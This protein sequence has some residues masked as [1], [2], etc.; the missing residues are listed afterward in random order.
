MRSFRMTLLPAALLVL[1]PIDLLA[2][3]EIDASRMRMAESATDKGNNFLKKQNYERAEREFTRAIEHES[4]YPQAHLGLAAVQVATGRYQQALAAV[5]ASKEHFQWWARLNQTSGLQDRQ[6]F[7]SREREMRDFARITRQNT[8][9]TTA[10]S[11]NAGGSVA[12]DAVARE[13]EME[14]HL[15]DRLQPE[16]VEGIPAQAFYL[17][18]L[19]QLRLGHRDKGIEALRTCLYLDQKHAL[20]HYN[21][22]VALF[23]TGEALAAK[24]HLDAAIEHGAEPHPQFVADL[25]AAVGSQ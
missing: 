2:G 16:E 24:V 11:G 13:V 18:G 9:A 7:A 4:R 8:G 14:R 3:P 6:E 15:A 19:A 21:L 22:A 25:N 20:S 5:A 10:E 1:A 12:S 23:T 17:E